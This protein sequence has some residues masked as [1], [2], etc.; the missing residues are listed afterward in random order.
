MQRAGK[1]FIIGMAAV[2]LTSGTLLTLAR[3]QPASSPRPAAAVPLSAAPSAAGV[4]DQAMTS[5]AGSPAATR[6]ALSDAPTITVYKTPTCGCCTAWVHHLENYGFRVE[7]HDLKSLDQI[8]KKHGISRNLESCHT[9]EV[10]GYIVEGHVPAD[11]IE[12]ML[13]ERPQIAGLAVPGMPMG[14]PGMEGPYRER[15][16]VLAFDRGGKLE[17]YDRR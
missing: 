17:I 10:D 3:R 4:A 6:L 16:N 8:K 7:A 11:L 14:S 1:F 2:V 9:A 15:Y 5:P 13:R 12:R